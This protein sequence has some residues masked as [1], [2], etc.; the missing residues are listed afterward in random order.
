MAFAIVHFTVGFI[1]ILTLLS[2]F[3][4]TRYRLT[5]AYAGGVWAI[6]P[7]IHH[8]ISGDLSQ[9]IYRLHNT[10]RADI[11]FFHHTLDGQFYR[12]HNMELTFLSLLV[13]GL[14]L[15]VYDQRFSVPVPLSRIFG[16]TEESDEPT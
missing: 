3:P 6:G 12:A 5:G 11:F 1:T 10:P 13:L 15:I 16:T 4:L 2:V 9:R 14:T 8:V 7:D